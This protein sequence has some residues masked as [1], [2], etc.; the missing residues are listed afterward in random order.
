MA[1]VAIVTDSTAYLAEPLLRKFEN[2]RVVPLTVNFADLAL[3]DSVANTPLFLEKLETADKLPT[4]SQPAPGD[5]LKVFQELSEQGYEIIAILFSSKLS[6]TVESALSAAKMCG[7]AKI[8]VIDS[9]TVSAPPY[10]SS[11]NCGNSCS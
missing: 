3:V 6:G 9:L 11:L 1:P 7:G 5:F 4:T 8:T 2:I 10:F